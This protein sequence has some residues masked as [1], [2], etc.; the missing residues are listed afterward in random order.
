M[1]IDVC[2][3]LS[4][5]VAKG[6]ENRSDDLYDVYEAFDSAYIDYQEKVQDPYSEIVIDAQEAQDRLLDNKVIDINQWNTL[7]DEV[8]RDYDA[9]QI[10]S[11][12]SLDRL[13]GIIYKSY[14]EIG[15]AFSD[16]NTDIDGIMDQIGE[17]V[18]A[19]VEE[20]YSDSE[21]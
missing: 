12:K 2:H 17:H 9:A 8:F 16:K 11:W 21:S 10:N 20:S 19:E 3:S 18:T 13:Y 5:S 6:N 4:D 7:Y 1:L 15:T 14:G